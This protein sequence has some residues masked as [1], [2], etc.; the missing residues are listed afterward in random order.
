M[1]LL[2]RWR[3][4]YNKIYTYLVKRSCRLGYR[5]KQVI[6]LVPVWYNILIYLILSYISLD[7]IFY[8]ILIVTAIDTF[9]GVPLL[10]MSAL[11]ITVVYLY[12]F[13]NNCRG[14][15]NIYILII[16]KKSIIRHTLGWIINYMYFLLCHFYIKLPS[17]IIYFLYI[18]D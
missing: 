1:S 7:I 10:K 2:L 13:L 16:P 11:Q 14:L 4:L 17:F 18:I 15:W 9:Q 3:K 8:T 12:N 6:R 5:F